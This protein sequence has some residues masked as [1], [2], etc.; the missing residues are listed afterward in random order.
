M[1]CESADA[2]TVPPRAA[3]GLT[4]AV[5]V[6]RLEREGAQSG[7]L[8]ASLLWSNASDLDLHV[9]SPEGHIDFR[10][11]RVGRGH[12]DV[13]MNAGCSMSDAPVE[14][15]FFQRPVPGR[16][17]VL[18]HNYCKRSGDGNDVFKVFLS[19]TPRAGAEPVTHEFVGAVGHKAWVACFEF[20]L[21]DG[22][23]GVDDSGDDGT[24]ADEAEFDTCIKE[25]PFLDVLKTEDVDALTCRKTLVAGRPCQ[26]L[27]CDGGQPLCAMFFGP[28]PRAV[29]TERGIVVPVGASEDRVSADMLAMLNTNGGRYAFWSTPLCHE[30]L[31]KVDFFM[32]RHNTDT[33]GVAL[34]AVNCARPFETLCFDA[35]KRNGRFMTLNTVLGADGRAKTLAAHEKETGARRANVR[36]RMQLTPSGGAASDALPRAIWHEERVFTVDMPKACPAS[37][38]LEG[39]V[40]PALRTITLAAQPKVP[41]CLLAAPDAR[42]ASLFAPTEYS[43]RSV[44]SPTSPAYSPTSP[45]YSPTSPSYS[46]MSPSYSPT[47]PSYSP[48]S[49]RYSPTSPRYSPTNYMS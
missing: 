47:S 27:R 9:L 3:E 42:T 36:F 33:E 30:G 4:T 7:E 35:D 37:S 44:Y 1:H 2:G 23:I 10:Q 29:A 48:T 41:E 19:L 14:N 31:L 32:E 28:P 46:P 18:V 40:G 26:V 16:Y 38:A 21:D 6:S 25:H 17:T 12:L 22:T 39:A 11:K 8:R 45:S 49:P 24:T 20:T 13:D 5:L 15:V 34:N 43:T